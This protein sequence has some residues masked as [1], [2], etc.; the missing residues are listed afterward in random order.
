[1]N[2]TNKSKII[3]SALFLIAKC[4]GVC[5]YNF[6]FKFGSAP[7]FNKILT[8]VIFCLITATWSGV[9]P[10]SFVI[11]GFAPFFNNNFTWSIFSISTA[12]YK[13]VSP[14]VH[15][16]F[17]LAPLFS[18]NVVEKISPAII[19]LYRGVH[20]HSSGIFILDKSLQNIWICFWFWTVLFLGI[21]FCLLEGVSKLLTVSL[22][23]IYDYLFE[24]MI[25]LF[26]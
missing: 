7:Y 11:F 2:C 10:S 24:K 21:K 3:G 18:N 16:I 6:D 9:N 23:N 22:D 1:M 13:G 12:W 5:W 15:W 19:V 20:P 26:T 17:G 25:Y 4:N 8:I 14:I